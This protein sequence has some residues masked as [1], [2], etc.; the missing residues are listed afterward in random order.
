VQY[1]PTAVPT[2]NPVEFPPAKFLD[3]GK[4]ELTRPDGC[5]V[6]FVARPEGGGLWWCR[7]EEPTVTVQKDLK[8]IIRSRQQ[9]TGESYSAARVHVMREHDALL[10]RTGESATDSL[11]VQADAVVL[12]VNQ[13]S[14]RVRL[15]T[16]TGQ[17]TFRCSEAPL[18][19]PGQLVT[20]QI[21]RRWIW[22][23]DAYGSGRM[24]NPRIDM[25][26]LGVLPLPLNGGDLRELG[27]EEDAFQ[28]PDPYASMWK[29]LTAKPRPAF[30]FDPI[31]WGSLPGH[32]IDHPPF[33]QAG[34][35]REQ[36]D[37]DAAREILMDILVE[38]IR[39]IEAHCQLGNIVFDRHPA[40][41]FV[42]YEI[43]I[44][45][46]ELS[47]PPGFDGLLSWGRIYNRPFLRCLHGYGLC[48]WRQGRIVEAKSVFER[49][50]SLNPV[51]NQGVRFCWR[52]LTK[53]LSWAES[54]ESDDASDMRN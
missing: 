46:G 9:K 41:A 24:E 26:G 39:C 30:E 4:G 22:H 5:H 23:G 40:E 33:A 25:I 44:R 49:I 16:E 2:P 32:E 53:G 7:N 17:I 12:K 34:A 19:A 52:D 28:R 45:I 11:P 10:G 14:V 37:D 15:Q 8:H 54:S 42:H 51:D 27:R 47:L 6:I 35:C 20:L 50:L 18:A 3:Q 1:L 43:G 29:K 38:D 36:G 21:A 48:L 13:Q 31:A